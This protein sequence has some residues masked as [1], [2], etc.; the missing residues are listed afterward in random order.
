MDT[1]SEDL[2]NAINPIKYAVNLLQG[3]LHLAAAKAGWWTDLET[4]KNLAENISP[5]LVA[6]KLALIHS[7]V[8]E[9]LEG[10]RTN[11]MDEKLPD[12]PAITVEL[13]DA[14]IRIFDLAGAMQ[15]NLAEALYEK[16]LYNRSRAD[17]KPENRNKVNGKRF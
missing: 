13:A 16:M 8:S 17:H 2:S 11:S 9:A 3:T 5:M 12:H 15:L 1:T 10:Y 4:R 14:L 6:T 7:E